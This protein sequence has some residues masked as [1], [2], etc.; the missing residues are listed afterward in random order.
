MSR[1]TVAPVCFGETEVPANSVV[2]GGVYT[3]L[4]DPASFPHPERFD[5]NRWVNQATCPHTNVTFGGGARR[6]LG[7]TL[8]THLMQTALS[9]I[10]PRF[11]LTVVPG[12]RIDRCA[13]L[14]LRP[15]PGIPVLV[16]NQD[17]NFL[18][19]PVTGAIHEMVELPVATPARVAA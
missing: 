4:H 10:V 9:L 8:A 2:V 18:A 12:A 1:V 14:T 15:D 6:C 16:R 3:T 19:S 17:R 7:A 11:R 13:S 5:P